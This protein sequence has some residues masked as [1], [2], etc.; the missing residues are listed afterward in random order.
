MNVDD[1]F[2]FTQFFAEVLIL[3][4]QLLVFFVQGAALGLGATLLWCQGMQDSRGTLVPPRHQ[5]RGVQAL[6]PEQGTDAT[7]LLFGLIGFGQDSLLV[8]GCEDAAPGSGDDLGVGAAGTSLAGA[9][10]VGADPGGFG[11]APLGLIALC[12]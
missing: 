5:V 3:A 6:T 11:L 8:L 7:R 10:L 12:G 4:T 1:D 9:S 2:R